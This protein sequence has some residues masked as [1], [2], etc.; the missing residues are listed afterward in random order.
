VTASIRVEPLG[1]SAK[2]GT[3]IKQLPF[4]ITTRC[5]RPK[6]YF[7]ELRSTVCRAHK[8]QA[9][10]QGRT[11]VEVDQF[12]HTI[13]KDYIF[14]FE[15]AM[16]D[17]ILME[18]LQAT[19]HLP[20]SHANPINVRPSKRFARDSALESFFGQRHDECHLRLM[21][22][23]YFDDKRWAQ[24]SARM[25]SH[26]TF[27]RIGIL[28]DL[29]RHAHRFG[30]FLS[31]FVFRS[32]HNHRPRREERDLQVVTAQMQYQVFDALPILGPCDVQ[33]TAALEYRARLKK[34]ARRTLATHYLKIS[35]AP[36][37]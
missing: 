37:Q 2:L 32:P 10:T 9:A 20:C 13:V 31:L 36:L 19:S 34:R 7:S 25:Q 15:V 4:D 30:L 27:E 33:A 16:D 12:P 26:F 17:A 11:A 18:M 35:F 24:P 8:P 21:M 28:H 3:L 6:Y 5:V 1:R 23:Q 14:G 22:P 29:E